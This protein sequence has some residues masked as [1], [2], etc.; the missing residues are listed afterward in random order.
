MRTEID[1]WGRNPF[2]A[3]LEPFRTIRRLEREMDRMLEDFPIYA[4]RGL[5]SREG[6][7]F[8]PACEVEETNHHYLVSFDLPGV[9]K[10]ELHVEVIGNE[11]VVSGERKQERKEESEGKYFTERQHGRFQ[12]SFTLPS[13]I[14]AEKLEANYQDGVLRIAIP[15][16]PGAKR[17]Q[18]S[19]G[20][21][22]TGWWDKLLGKGE[23][24]K[25]KEKT[26]KAA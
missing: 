10:S 19:I 11:L 21:A 4:S 8:M 24:K 15:K 23:E 3:T 26:V 16:S 12:R 14:S 20:E 17:H 2:R 18:V 7:E 1:V 6:I 22:K 13:E 5:Q 9:S 25:E